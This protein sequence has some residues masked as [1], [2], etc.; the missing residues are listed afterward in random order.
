MVYKKVTNLKVLFLFSEEKNR[1][2]KPWRQY[3]STPNSVTKSRIGLKLQDEN[4]RSEPGNP[5]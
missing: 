3:L 2:I 5:M 1:V 4:S